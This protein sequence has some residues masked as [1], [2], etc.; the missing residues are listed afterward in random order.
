MSVATSPVDVDGVA[1]RLESIEADANGQDDLQCAGVHRHPRSCPSIDPTF[2]EKVRVFEIAEQPKVDGQRH[3]QPTFRCLASRFRRGVLCE[4]VRIRL[5]NLQAD[6]EINDR[7][8]RDQ[9][10]KSPI[11]PAVKQV[12]RRENE[13]VLSPENLRSIG[14]NIQNPIRRKNTGQ[15]QQEFNGV[16]EHDVTVF[17]P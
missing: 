9:A 8:K 11:P 13:Q 14:P 6:E 5:L 12:A 16:E 4:F 10:Q 7:G 15:E 3:P 17:R 1:T 2:D